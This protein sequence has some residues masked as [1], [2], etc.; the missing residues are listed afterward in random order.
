MN[1]SLT[2]DQIAYIESKVKGGGYQTSSEVV[3]EALRLMQERDTLQAA[4]LQA[5]EKGLISG[6]FTVVNPMQSKGER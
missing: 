6:E 2:K 4:R 3:R 5:V 1:V